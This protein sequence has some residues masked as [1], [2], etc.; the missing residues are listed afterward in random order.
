MH[1]ANQRYCDMEQ[2]LAFRKPQNWDCQVDAFM[3]HELCGTCIKARG[4]LVQAISDELN[5]LQ[6]QNLA[7]QHAVGRIADKY[8]HERLYSIECRVQQG[9][10]QDRLRCFN[11]AW[12]CTGQKKCQQ[13][14]LLL[15]SVPGNGDLVDPLLMQL[16]GQCYQLLQCKVSLLLHWDHIQSNSLQVANCFDTSNMLTRTSLWYDH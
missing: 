4:K 2:A 1:W 14:R 5:A 10:I 11:R 12:Q 16:T 8:F 3:Q 13:R 6:M 9:H 7:Q 15:Q